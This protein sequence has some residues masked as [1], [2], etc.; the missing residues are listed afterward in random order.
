MNKQVFILLVL[1]CIAHTIFGQ[2]IYNVGSIA[3]SLTNHADAVIRFYNTSYKNGANGKCITD[4]HYAITVLNPNGKHTAELVI[5]YDQNTHITDI[6]GY[7]YNK[8]GVLQHKLK[9]KDIRD[10]AAN[11][12]YTL[13]SDNRV[14][15]FIP[16]V[17]AYP[18]TIEYKYTVE[19][20]G[21]AGFDTWMPQR[22]FNIAIESAKLSFCTNGE[23]DFKYLELNHDFIKHISDTNNTKSFTW[24]VKNLKAVEFEPH[25]PNYLDFMPA[26]LLS[27]GKVLFEKTEGDFS[28]WHSYGKWV[29]SLINGRDELSEETAGYIK[30]LTDTIHIKKIR[31]KPSINICKARPGMSVLLWELVVFNRCL[32]WM[33]IQKDMVTVKP[34]QIILKPCFNV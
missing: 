29:Y 28:T 16:A 33:W 18:F 34:C 6:K 27:P 4:E 10:Y 26:V 17:T 2:N 21:T 23:S 11:G 30:S 32:Q 3:D 20:T 1:I 19:N 8:N 25:A 12:D 9:K 13:F 7:L 31:L 14:K 5:Y 22:W 15:H 24:E